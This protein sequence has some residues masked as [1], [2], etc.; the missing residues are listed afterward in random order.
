MGVVKKRPTGV[1]IIVI[2]NILGW[3]TTEGMWLML[4]VSH[5]IPSVSAMNSFFE[6]S[7]IGLVNGFTV[8]DAVWSNITLLISIFGLWKMKDW[9]WT[10]AIMANII[11][12]YTMTFT[13]VR[14]LLVTITPGMIFFSIFA[15]FAIISTLYLWKIRYLFWHD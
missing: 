3:I 9:G 14:D 4:H 5:Q 8:A 10:A 2:I 11:W 1:T 12:L 15:L 13:T 7:Y 6:R